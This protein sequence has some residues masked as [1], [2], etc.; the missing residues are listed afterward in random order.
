MRFLYCLYF[1]FL[2]CSVLF[3]LPSK[4]ADLSSNFDSSE[5]FFFLSE[6]S[7]LDSINS[8]SYDLY[9][10]RHNNKYSVFDDFHFCSFLCLYLP[11][12]YSNYI[13]T[14]VNF[15]DDSIWSS[16]SDPSF[17]SNKLTWTDV[18][19]ELFFPPHIESDFPSFYLTE[20]DVDFLMKQVPL[21]SDDFT[22]SFRSIPS[23]PSSSVLPHNTWSISSLITSS[24]SGSNTAANKNFSVYYDF[25]LTPSSTFSLFYSYADDPFNPPL[26]E[27]TPLWLSWELIGFSLKYSFFA[28]S[29]S[30]ISISSSLES[31]GVSSLYFD[32]YNSVDQ[33][34]SI[35]DD[36]LI[37]SFSFFY[38][39]SL[40]DS[41]EFTISPGI[42][43]LP[44]TLHQDGH[45]S[46]SF[47]GITP[48]LASG[49]N[50]N[51]KRK[52]VNVITLN[53]K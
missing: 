37:G 28:D 25:G 15:F 38:S 20:P 2:V 9:I 46:S 22:K 6:F 17:P 24:F 30:S 48:Y 21:T 23:F 19:Q 14:G 52:Q 10:Y 11:H 5:S 47:F 34:S 33:A 7:I 39:L 3:P 53:L 42:N 45:H 27:S 26:T 8:C 44:A 32:D 50:W 35:F 43:F 13:I 18:D 51:L 29:F 36:Y 1:F 31:W 12:S 49:L 41:L 40:I 16:S 4:S